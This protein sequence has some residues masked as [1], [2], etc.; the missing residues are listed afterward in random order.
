M[1]VFIE[2]IRGKESRK[3]QLDITESYFSQVIGLY[4]GLKYFGEEAK[5]DVKHMT[6]EMIK[7]YQ[8]RLD[9]MN[10]SVVQRLIRL[11]KN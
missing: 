4:Y 1:D 7:V 3:H 11:L 10:G 6:S 9:K 2:C 5:S 8:E